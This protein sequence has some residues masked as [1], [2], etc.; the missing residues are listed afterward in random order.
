MTFCQL[1][2]N[3]S[4]YDAVQQLAGIAHLNPLCYGCRDRARTHFNALRY[5]YVDLT[6]LLPKVDGRRQLG[7][8]F[9]PKPESQPPLNS[10]ALHLRADIVLFA[11]V[12][13]REL[14]RVLG[15][16]PW[17]SEPVR[18]GFQLDTETSLL[19]SNIDEVARLPQTTAYFT[20]ADDPLTLDGAGIFTLAGALHRKARRLCGLQP[21]VLQVPGFCPAC[22]RAGLRRHDD[23]DS[24]LWCSMCGHRM[25]MAEHAAQALL[26][27][28]FPAGP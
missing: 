12:T 6:Q 9:R 7:R 18:E 10:A 21:A 14:R 1:G 26:Q 25:A 24:K 13:T 28:Q 27:V 15:Y 4:V 19:C 22:S 20:D 3:C 17:R 2:R 8:I 11:G 16:K 23:D 5:D